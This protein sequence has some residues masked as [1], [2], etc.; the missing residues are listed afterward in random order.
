MKE[1]KALNK[2]VNNVLITTVS[3]Y[4]LNFIPN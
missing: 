1:L 3:D 2:K 4:I